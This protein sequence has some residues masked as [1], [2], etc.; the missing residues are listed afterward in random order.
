MWIVDVISRDTMRV[1]RSV[2]YANK[3]NAERGEKRMLAKMDRVLEY[4]RIRVVDG[5]R[6]AD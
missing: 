3:R 2:E 6:Q 5:E 4:T 1:A